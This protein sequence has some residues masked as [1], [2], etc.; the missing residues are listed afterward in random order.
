M[1]YFEFRLGADSYELCEKQDVE[2]KSCNGIL[3]ANQFYSLS[4]YAYTSLKKCTHINFGHFKSATLLKTKESFTLPLLQIFLGLK[5]TAFVILLVV[6]LTVKANARKENYFRK[7]HKTLSKMRSNDPVFAYRYPL[8]IKYFDCY[9][10]SK[11]FYEKTEDQFDSLN[12]IFPFF[13]RKSALLKEN[14]Y[15]N[16]FTKRHL[17]HEEHVVSLSHVNTWEKHNEGYI[18]ASFIPGPSN[19]N[20]TE[21]ILAQ[22]M[23][24]CVK[25]KRIK[26]LKI[27]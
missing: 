18:N 14:F 21:Y 27:Q 19:K 16:R 13:S 23:Y 7:K 22:G 9:I 10:N 6:H 1:S 24:S 11:D 15:R 17:P 12:R 25:R 4:L 20:P 2:N 5:I 8:W 26:E 3:N